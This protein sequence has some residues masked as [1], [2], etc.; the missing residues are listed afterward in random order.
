MGPIMRPPALVLA[1]FVPVLLAGAPA[2]GAG[3][4]VD[5]ALV[6][7]AD[8]SRSIDADE[9]ALEKQG[10]AGAFADP[11]VL[12]AIRSG[13]RGTIAV[14]YVEFAG[15]DEVR[16]VVDWT[17]VQ[18]AAGAASFAGRLRGAER[19]FYGRTSISAGID[20]AARSL[21]E[22][23]FSAARRLIDVSGDGTNNAGRPVTDARDAAVAA[24]ITINGLTIINDHPAA[25]TF[26]HVQPPGGLTRYYRDNVIG[27]PGS[28]VLEVRDF[29]SF[30]EAMT[31]KLVSEIAERRRR[32]PAVD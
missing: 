31:R 30:G 32:G 3:P 9:Y 11:K 14:C 13:V 27:G 4:A 23:G 8:V 16:R 10:Y 7:L 17:V 28:F 2:S 21:A 5:L 1:L 25:Y 12:A 29:P 18:D 6:L 26:A 19:S 24:G 22:T 15:P 20:R